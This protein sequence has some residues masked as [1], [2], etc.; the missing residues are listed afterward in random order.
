VAKSVADTK[1]GDKPVAQVTINRAAGNAF[2]D[3]IADA[4]RSGGLN[5]KV[6]Q[7]KDTPF[8]RRVI[9]IEVSRGTEVLGGIE[10]KL[11]DSRYTAPQ[12]AKDAYLNLVKGYVVTVVRS[13]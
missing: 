7:P 6:E 3:E 9:D 12:R 10:T 5:A 13:K 2:R 4:L 1:S 11:G 8:G